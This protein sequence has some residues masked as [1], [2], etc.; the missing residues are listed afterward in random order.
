MVIL[1]K[2]IEDLRSMHDHEDYQIICTIAI[3][4]VYSSKRIQI[5]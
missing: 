3:L 2:L 4:C 5:Q 1:N